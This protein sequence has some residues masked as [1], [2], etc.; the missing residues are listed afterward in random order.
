MAKFQRLGIRRF[1]FFHVLDD[2]N[3]ETL[4]IEVDFSLKSNRVAWVL[5]RL[6][7]KREKPGRIRMDKGPEFIA[8]LMAEWSQMH[9]IA[10]LYIQAGK[11]T[12]KAFVAKFN[13]TFRE[14]VLHA[15]LFENL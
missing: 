10:F 2:Y 6:I 11:P 12:Q 3:R 15:Y 5:N 8:S 13:G 1:R 7:K 14:Q 4:H 9:V